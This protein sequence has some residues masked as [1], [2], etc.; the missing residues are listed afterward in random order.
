MSKSLLK[1]IPQFQTT[2]KMPKQHYLENLR[3]DE[4]IIVDDV[5][6]PH[7]RLGFH[8]LNSLKDKSL[9]KKYEKAKADLSEKTWWMF[10]NSKS[11]EI[12]EEINFGQVRVEI[13]SSY[14]KNLS[15]K[16]VRICRYT[17]SLRYGGLFD[18]D[19]KTF[20]IFWIDQRHN[21]IYQ[22]I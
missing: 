19:Q 14:N 20:Y 15:P 1:N 4:K 12:V 5:T 22:H 7:T 13:P 10:M 2:D 9:V 18:P 16:K 3:P 17:Y 11:K 21:D 8:K 6:H